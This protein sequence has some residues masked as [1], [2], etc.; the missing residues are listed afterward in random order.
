MSFIPGYRRDLFIS[1]A[2]I[3]N[4]ARV[5]NDEDSRWVSLFRQVLLTHLSI[6]LGERSIIDFWDLAHIR[7]N[8][9][10]TEQ[11]AD[12]I[13]NSA[14]LLV[15]LSPGYLNS[16]WCRQERETFLG[17]EKLSAK[18]GRVAVVSL[19]EL[20]RES[21]QRH[22]LPDL[23]DY[24]FYDL[25]PNT[26]DVRLLGT[27][28]LRESDERKYYDRLQR[29]CRD[30][31]IKLRKMREEQSAVFGAGIRTLQH[32]AIY[33]LDRRE[34]DSTGALT[35]APAVYLATVGPGLMDT[36]HDLST[37]L[38]QSG[39][40]V[41]PKTVLPSDP[42]SFRQRVS[43]QL[44]DAL[45]FVQL[46]PQGGTSQKVAT[47]LP[48]DFDTIQ[49]ECAR[50]AGVPIFRRRPPRSLNLLTVDAKPDLGRDLKEDA[51]QVDIE[52]FKFNLL[53]ELR[54]LVASRRMKQLVLPAAAGN[55]AIVAPS[56]ERRAESLAQELESLHLGYEILREEDRL[57][58]LDE[59]DA[60]DGMLVVYDG[61]SEDW[62]R[63][64]VRECRNLWMKL[65]KHLR[66]PPV[67]GIYRAPEPPSR[68]LLTRPAEFL[69][70][71]AA[72]P[73]ALQPF[74]ERV[75]ARR[76]RVENAKV[77]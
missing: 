50:T 66:A 17:E 41:L 6:E 38:L 15:L 3:D 2:G 61:A 73:S 21:W 28:K 27:P 5:P 54:R 57:T 26:G 74:V 53:A 51:Q 16:E 39:F 18:Q 71:D 48:A 58:E 35:S 32:P 11:I 31:T 24:A 34:A 43:D 65:T 60:Y 30:L 22:F 20:E 14:L 55:V 19:T 29:L 9:P 8:E 1:Y 47:D 67:I 72:S 52:E 23:R 7:G 49:W 77:A 69:V 76:L 45:A 75:T 10:L 62:V 25:N 59:P 63:D 68:R 64:R 44:Q 13:R 40:E 46:L 70:I 33:E 36:R 12:E 37:W 56:K 4:L 42:P